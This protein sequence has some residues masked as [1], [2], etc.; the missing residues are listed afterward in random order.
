[1]TEDPK[2]CWLLGFFSDLLAEM[3]ETELALEQAKLASDQASRCDDGFYIARSNVYSARALFSCGDLERATEATRAVERL[4]DRRTIP[5]TEVSTAS[6]WKARLWL[7]E[8]Q[9]EAAAQW[10]AEHGYNPDEE[11]S[12]AREVEY[13][14]LARVLTAQGRTDETIQ[15]LEWARK[16][17]ESDNRLAAQIEV[18]SLE[19]LAHHSAGDVDNALDLLNRALS[20]AEPA[21]FFRI[22]LDEGPQMARLL[23]EAATRDGSSQYIRRSLAEFPVTEGEAT[24]NEN[25]TASQAD[26]VER[27]S[28]REVDV[29]RLMAEGLS[30]E[31]VGEKL[32][33]SMHTVKVHARNIYAKLDAHNRTEAV[34]RA[35][36]F[37]ILTDSPPNPA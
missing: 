29:L 6:A 35:R 5:V 25:A 12:R 23:Y 22:F 2:F 18:L 26:L 8:G 20:L 19:A 36:Y 32:F 30:N 9:L 34:A 24:G 33:I 27:L 14:A 17:A 31:Q 16:P 3:D 13:F 28:E 15:L 1:M 11:P 4:A 37:G 21:G 10:A 7:A